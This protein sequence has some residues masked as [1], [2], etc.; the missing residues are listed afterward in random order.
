VPSIFWGVGRRHLLYLP[1]KPA[2]RRAA[3]AKS[4]PR[5]QLRPAVRSVRFALSIIGSVENPKRIGPRHNSS[6]RGRKILPPAVLNLPADGN[7]LSPSGPSCP[8][9]IDGSP[10]PAVSRRHHVVGWSSRPGL[11]RRPEVHSLIHSSRTRTHDLQS[12]CHC[13]RTSERNRS[14][15][16][17]LE[18]SPHCPHRVD[19]L[20][21]STA[22]ASSC[23][24]CAPQSHAHALRRNRVPDSCPQS[25][26]VSRPQL[27]TAA[28]ND[29]S[30][31][32]TRN[33][34]S[35]PTILY[36]SS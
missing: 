25:C 23:H 29:T 3:L 32:E 26:R 5:R 31:T 12:A 34:Y 36:L 9:A 7:T 21:F 6:H 35:A 2:S 20:C 1:V 27:A 16:F 8:G 33:P 11:V 18:I 22:R 14:R 24:R 15:F 4:A 19:E 30:H 17:I 28:A 13:C 10:Y